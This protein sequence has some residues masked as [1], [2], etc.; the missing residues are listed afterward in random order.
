MDQPNRNQQLNEKWKE[1][2]REVHR[3]RRQ[4]A[5]HGGPMGRRAR[6]ERYE[7]DAKRERFR[8][9]WNQEVR[10]REQK[11][12]S[13]R[14]ARNQEILNAQ[15]LHPDLQWDKNENEPNVE[16]Q[17]GTRRKLRRT[18]KAKR[19]TRKRYFS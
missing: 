14:A 8:R 18:Q 6:R 4:L 16:M 2:N 10:K 7:G 11:R 12:E 5:W 17:G 15:N 1:W 13:R 3:V 19:S 9:H